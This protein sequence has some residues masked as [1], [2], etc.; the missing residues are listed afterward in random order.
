MDTSRRS[1]F[2]V[3][4]RSGIIQ[5]DDVMRLA[6]FFMASFAD[7]M[8]VIFVKMFFFCFPVMCN[9]FCFP[10]ICNFFDVLHENNLIFFVVN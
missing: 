5:D 6:N 4:I 10:I 7:E 2:Y 8:N 1:R 3:F 9:F